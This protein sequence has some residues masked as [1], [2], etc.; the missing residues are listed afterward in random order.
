MSEYPN[1]K[2]VIISIED[3]EDIDFDQIMQ[4]DAK[5]LRISTDGK[6]TFVKFQGDTPSFLEGKTQ[7]THEEFK[8]IINDV[9]GNWTADDATQGAIIDNLRDTISG[10]TWDKV[11]PFNW[12]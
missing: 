6:Y 11:N 4:T 3:V 5:S 1:K 2:Y 9:D 10:I 7:Y 12:F 8:V